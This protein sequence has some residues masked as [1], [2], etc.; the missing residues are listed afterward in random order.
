MIAPVETPRVVLHN[1]E[2]GHLEAQEIG[3]VSEYCLLDPPGG[4]ISKSRDFA[5]RTYLDQ[6][7]TIIPLWLERCLWS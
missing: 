5:W 2:M 1:G 6:E 4:V 3:Y 7:H